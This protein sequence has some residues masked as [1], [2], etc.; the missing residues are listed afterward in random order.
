MLSQL[1]TKVRNVHR[2][3]FLTRSAVLQ[4][5]QR[6]EVVAIVAED[7]GV[8]VALLGRPVERQV[9]STHFQRGEI[10]TW[11]QAPQHFVCSRKEKEKSHHVTFIKCHPALL[12]APLG[13]RLF[14]KNR[15]TTAELHG[16]ANKPLEGLSPEMTMTGLLRI[17]QSTNMWISS[18]ELYCSPQQ[19]AGESVDAILTRLSHSSFQF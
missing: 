5:H 8:P 14:P 2:C 19:A 6:Y 10:G 13:V 12:H 4:C 1:L 16:K 17:L 7:D 3:R 15:S 18:K 11:L 9:N